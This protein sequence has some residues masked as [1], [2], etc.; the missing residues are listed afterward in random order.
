MRKVNLRSVD[1]NLLVVLE[2][3][4]DEKQVTRAAERLHMSQPAVSRALQRLRD[5]FDDP[6][7]VRSADGY[8]LS[9]RAEQIQS[10]LKMILQQVSSMISEP[11]FTPSSS[12]MVVKIAG[13]D[14]ETALYVPDLL[15]T[16][17]KAS[18]DMSIEI[19]SR[20]ADYFD[21]LSKGEIHFAI[22][23]VQ[24]KNAEDQFHRTLLDTTQI[25]VMM[26]EQ[27]PLASSDLTYE[28]YLAA[29][30]GYVSLTGKGPAMMDSRLKELGKK[31]NTVLRLTS[32][33][34][35]ADYCEKTD[36]LFMLP[37]NLIDKLSEGRAVVKRPLPKELQTEPLSFYLYWH[38]RDHKDPMHKW[39]R[40]L[41]QR[42]A[43]QHSL[44]Q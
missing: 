14:L 20:P 33:M 9:V 27:H 29:R 26:G 17:R 10:E 28:D 5:T 12:K 38:A 30:H 24:P 32:F 18:P 23:G 13:P 37:V 22:S 19:D 35:V 16:M 3:L 21:M 1:L 6:L 39:V 42:Q 40:E 36:L 44:N 41:L 2:A 11:V 43:G 31:R 7:L 34:G 15:A 25:A 4:L 8:G